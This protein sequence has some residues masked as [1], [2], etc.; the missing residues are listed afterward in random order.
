MQL[1]IKE[2]TKITMLSA[3]CAVLAASYVRAEVNQAG[4]EIQLVDASSR[5]NSYRGPEIQTL[6]A[7]ILVRDLGAGKK[8]GMHYRTSNNDWV[9]AWGSYLYTMGDGRERWQVSFAPCYAYSDPACS[10][11]DPDFAV[12]MDVG[13]QSYW[14]N[15][16]GANYHLNR[17]S[18][19]RLANGFKAF[20]VSPG[21][22]NRSQ[23]PGAA[24]YVYGRVLVENLATAKTVKMIYTVNG[25]QTRAELP[26]TWVNGDQLYP[27]ERFTNPGEFGGEAWEFSLNVPEGNQLEYYIQYDVNGQRFY[28]SNFGRNYELAIP[29]RPQM[30][31]RGTTGDWQPQYMYASGDISGNLTYNTAP[32]VTGH[33]PKERFKFDVLG[34]WAVNYGDNDNG[35]ASRGG[36]A[37]RNGSDIRFLDGPGPYK[38]SFTNH[39]HAFSVAKQAETGPIRRTLVFIYGRT[40]AGQDMYIRGGI[41]H[42]YSQNVLHKPCA[43]TAGWENPCAIPLRHR[44]R[45]DRA[46]YAGDWFLDW[47][48]AGEHQTAAAQGS[49][50]IWTTNDAGYARNIVKDTVGY[51]PLNKYGEHYWML[52][53][54]MDC[55]RTV[56]GWFEAKSFI[57]N[58]P[59]WEN[60]VSQPGAP[61]QSP[62]HFGKC[63]MVNVFR[64]GD[65]AARISPF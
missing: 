33:D 44:L 5:V 13:G 54:D 26:L 42:G 28:D 11:I 53:V 49:P 60:D 16:G 63:G 32:Y 58:G 38:V 22:V 61:W 52:D 57:S 29:E 35:G 56:D 37:D 6:T 23:G 8:V 21:M 2:I 50:L 25:W 48:G 64:R 45:W 43:D 20:T 40:V 62:N 3:T 19:Y 1:N 51:T 18:G 36:I 17:Q 24:L 59:G 30:T 34:D 31:L 4:G 55:S 15:N 65:S 9:D 47:Y 7:D 27:P 39:S 46:D 41:D 12:R 10:Q 14:D